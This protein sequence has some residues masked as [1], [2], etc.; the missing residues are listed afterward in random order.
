MKII[1]QLCTAAALCSLLCSFAIT[2]VIA[3]QTRSKDSSCTSCH[4][5][6][7]NCCT[8]LPQPPKNTPLPLE[9]ENCL[10]CFES[11]DLPSGS[12]D[13]NENKDCQSYDAMCKLFCKPLDYPG[14]Q[15]PGELTYTLNPAFI[16]PPCQKLVNPP[17]VPLE[18]QISLEGKH[19]LVI[20]GSKGIGK[21]VAKRL[22]QAGAHVIATSRHPE[23][24]KKPKTYKL[25][26]LDV[27]LEDE[28]KS[29]INHVAR[30]EFNGQIDILVNCAVVFYMGP[31]SEATGTDVLNTLDNDLV[32]YHRVVHY[33]LPY[34]RHS[35]ETR[36]I[37][38]GSMS[39]E[40]PIVYFG[41]AYAVSKLGMQMWND[42]LMLEEL[43]KK[44]QGLVKYGPTF[45]LVEPWYTGTTNGLYEYYRASELSAKDPLVLGA[46]F[47][48]T[49]F[50]PGFG[51]NT[52]EFVAEAVHNIAVAPQPG[53]RYGIVDPTLT[54]DVP[55]VGPIP[56]LEA[57]QIIHSVSQDDVI[58]TAAQLALRSI[59]NK[60]T[61]KQLITEGYCKDCTH[62]FNCHKAE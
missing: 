60:Q 1:K 48:T 3:K 32:G 23:C 44:A 26:Q 51:S 6:F 18:D 31:L 62:N 52:T 56:I 25:L 13:L 57:I 10:C 2:P 59:A 11:R 7:N 21:A 22:R 5:A 58:K 24:Y 54:V 15:F 28:V 61:S 14:I 55:G 36:V 12:H 30:K 37:S 42:S 8:D 38:F 43:V 53:V 9:G 20:G 40:V 50:L 16:V 19:V 45:S 4:D 39:A 49:A 47:D 27:R 17:V 41:S 46:R 33:A 29:F 34:M 35:N